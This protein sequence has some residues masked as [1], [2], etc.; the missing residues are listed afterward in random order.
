MKLA[1]L[2]R[3]PSTAKVEAGAPSVI[4]RIAINRF[5]R[6]IKRVRLQYTPVEMERTFLFPWEKPFKALVWNLE[7][8]C[9]LADGR[10]FTHFVVS[11]SPL[12]AA[13]D[14]GY[15]EGIRKTLALLHVEKQA[16][17]A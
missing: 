8:T 15:M 10:E 14:Y 5:Y 16:R 11:Q 7:V 12:Q 3:G 1:Q 2:L 17:A 4:E 13:L 9:V 6:P